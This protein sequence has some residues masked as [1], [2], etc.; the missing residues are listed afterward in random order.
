MN[1][2]IWAEVQAAIIA[3]SV[4]SDSE[5]ERAMFSRIVPVF[6]LAWGSFLKGRVGFY[7][8]W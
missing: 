5:T 2:W 1:V 8:P 3:L 7:G 4:A 6:L